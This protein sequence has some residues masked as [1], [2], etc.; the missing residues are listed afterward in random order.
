MLYRWPVPSNARSGPVSETPSLRQRLPGILKGL[1]VGIPAGYVFDLLDTP[2][3]WMIGPMVAVAACNLLLGTKLL[4]V[5]YGR[6]MGQVILGSAVSLYFTPAVLAMLLAHI[7]AIAASTVSAFVIGGLG[8]LLLSR[9]SGVDGKSTFFASIPGGAMAMAVLAE[10]YGAS[11]PAVAVAH[12][13]RVSIVVIVV[14][15]ALTYGGVPLEGFG[16]ARPHLDLVPWIL[17][18][19]LGAGFLVGEISERLKFHNGYLLMPIFMGS[20][21]TASGVELSAV[22]SQMTDFAQLMFGLVLGSRYD[23]D[24]FTRYRLF[25]PFALFNAFFV[26]AASATL[27]VLLAWLFGL[28]IATMIIATAPGGLPE[29]TITA[30]ALQIGVPLVVA[31]HL[32]RVVVVNIGAQHLFTTGVWLHRRFAAARERGT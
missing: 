6:Q 24:F 25:V 7:G 8:A 3:P 16:P 19:W 4:S 32:F 11:I 27:G 31:F 22:P 12:S 30:Q 2:I 15:Y 5:P 9:M 18:A 28:P 10:R 14:P 23:R 1:A 13:L 21:M 29:M 26:L 17:V 20:A